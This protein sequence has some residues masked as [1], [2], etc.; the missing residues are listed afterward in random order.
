MTDSPTDGPTGGTDSPPGGAPDPIVIDARTVGTV[1]FRA[2]TAAIIDAFAAGLDVAASPA[3][4]V[5]PVTAG[6][7]LLMP[8]EV[9]G[10]TGVKVASV[11]PDNPGLG[12]P[13]IQGS[14]LLLD[15]RTLGPLAI[16]DGPALTTLRTPA[17]SAAAATRLAGPGPLRTVAFGT[18]PQSRG[19]IE[20]LHQTVG[21]GEVSVIARDTERTAAFARTLHEELGLAARP[22]GIPDLA[23][24]DVVVC[25]TTAR[26]PLFRS[27]DVRRG[28]LV[29]AVGSHEPDVAELPGELLADAQVVVEDRATA[30]REAGDVIQA[31]RDAGLRE[32]S[33]VDLAELM[34]GTTDV[35]LSRTR[36]FKGVGMAWEDVVVAAHIFERVTGAGSSAEGGSDGGTRQ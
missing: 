6:Q 20:A 30:A 23:E 36:V 4:S 25:A 17:V 13:R 15:R 10:Y 27:D 24:A 26:R 29:I 8:G 1:T 21:L 28:A 12:L 18:G 19:H 7:L 32:E 35:D 2:A 3:R 22:G 33:L 34:R 5:V 11:A 14:F 31:M 16:I 9:G